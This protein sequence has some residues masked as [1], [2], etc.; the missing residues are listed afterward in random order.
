MIAIIAF[1]LIKVF[2]DK[3]P[4]DEDAIEIVYLNQEEK[5][6]TSHYL[7]LTNTLYQKAV[8]VSK[9]INHLSAEYL[10]GNLGKVE[11][12]TAVARANKQITYYYLVALQ[13]EKNGNVESLSKDLE[14][15]F[16][17]MRKGTEEMMKYSTDTS[18]LRIY[19]GRD[20]LSQVFEREALA[21]KEIATEIVRYDI[22]PDLVVISSEVWDKE[23]QFVQ[24]TPNMVAFQDL[25]LTDKSSYEYYLKY[26]N[27]AFMLVSWEMQNIYLTKI[28]YNNELIE[29]PQFNTKLDA[30]GYIITTAHDELAL[31]KAPEG[32][33]LLEEDTRKTMTLYRDA[34]LEIHKF[35]M[36]GDIKHFD[37]AM[38]IIEQADEQAGRIGEFIYA[39]KQQYGL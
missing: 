1:I 27:E 20:L 13:A 3:G 36:D 33:E 18:T 23:Y 12:D 15:D 39:I 2:S 4:V 25:D 34:L 19:V 37:N 7:V 28:D 32:L 22:D 35:R 24:E 21:N 6:E 5:L 17:L 16:Y 11:F 14:Y 29:R 9:E 8:E 26:V 31:L 30:S 38:V 10:Q